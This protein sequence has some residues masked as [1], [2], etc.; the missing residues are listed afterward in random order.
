[1]NPENKNLL[2]NCIRN[3][4]LIREP[5]AD[6]KKLME[7]ENVGLFANVCMNRIKAADIVDGTHIIDDSMGIAMDAEG[8]A[9]ARMILEGYVEPDILS[10]YEEA[11]RYQQELTIY[12]NNVLYILRRLSCKELCEMRQR[13]KITS[14]SENYEIDPELIELELSQRKWWNRVL[15]FLRYLVVVFDAIIEVQLPIRAI[16]MYLSLVLPTFKTK[17]YHPKYGG[18][19]YYKALKRFEAVHEGQKL[20]SHDD[21]KRYVFLGIHAFGKEY[22]QNERKSKS[23][24]F[25][26]IE[27][28]YG[29]CHKVMEA[30]GRITPR[31][32]MQMFPVEKKYDG[33]RQDEKDYFYTME[34]LKELDKPIGQEEDAACILWDYVN[35]TLD[36][37][38]ISWMDSVDDL[39]IYIGE[40]EPLKKWREA[41]KKR[42]KTGGV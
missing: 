2:I 29:Q 7:A 6:I 35:T 3:N 42:Y 14:D 15:R 21:L 38:F 10:K 5:L 30:I 28:K 31:E 27:W 18:A 39:K 37:F 36:F 13:I 24:T 1:M 19:K 23:K 22:L 25:Y 32:L 11:F 20:L 40:E 12:L 17:E 34:R 16:P 9:R 33:N 41:M 4:D 8:I 26:E